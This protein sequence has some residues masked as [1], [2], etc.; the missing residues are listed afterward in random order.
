M[1]SVEI[2]PD[3]RLRGNKPRRMAEAKIQAANGKKKQ[4]WQNDVFGN[5]IG[6]RLAPCRIQKHHDAAQIARIGPGGLRAT[7]ERLSHVHPPFLGAALHGQA[8]R[9]VAQWQLLG[10]LGMHAMRVPDQTIIHPQQHMKLWAV[11]HGGVFIQG[12]WQGLGPCLLTQPCINTCC[13]RS[14]WPRLIQEQ[15]RRRDQQTIADLIGLVVT[16]GKRQTRQQ[17]PQRQHR[18]KS[19]S[20]QV[21]PERPGCH[22]TCLTPNPHRLFHQ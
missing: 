19:P 15:L 10:Q 22:R 6:Q 16:G 11:S 4:R 2:W 1:S 13:I 8:Q 20:P 7:P 18:P 5:V 9:L 17:H 21:T 3:K 12:L 14:T